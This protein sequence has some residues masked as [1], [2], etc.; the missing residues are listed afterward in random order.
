MEEFLDQDQLDVAISMNNLASHYFFQGKYSEAEPLFKQS[1]STLEKILGK[2]N[3][4][5]GISLNNL[6]SL[7]FF[8]GRH[9]EAIPLFSR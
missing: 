4:E 2:E 7:Y 9:S 8:Q 5:V 3:L 1:I 6:A